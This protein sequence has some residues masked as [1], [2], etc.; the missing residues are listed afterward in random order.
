MNYPALQRVFTGALPSQ[1]SRPF[2]L[3]W[4]SSQKD[5]AGLLLIQ[6]L[7]IR[8]GLCGGIEGR[9]SCISTTIGAPLQLFLGQPVTVQLVTDQ[10]A[11]HSICA[12]VTDAHEGESDGSLATYQLVV[13]D[14]VSIMEQRINTRIF[15]TKSVVEIIQTLVQEWRRKSSTLGVTFDLDISNLDM[16]KYPVR[17]QTLQFDES[18]ANFFRR[19]CRREGIAW[20][21]R[22][23]GDQNNTDLSKQPFHALVLFDNAIKLRQAD[24][25]AV[26]YHSDAATG[27]R[28]AITLL[29]MGRQLV[30][31]SMRRASW[32]LKPSRV[33][34]VRAPTR[35]DQGPA[36]N[37]LAALLSDARIDS[38]HIAD[39]PDDYERLGMAR[40]LAH[41]ARSAIV[42][43]ASGVRDLEVGFWISVSGHPELDQLPEQQR[44]IVITSLNHAGENNL[45]KDLNERAQVLFTAS[46]WQAMAT[47]LSIDTPARPTA[48][49][50]SSASRYENTFS[51]VPR[52]TPL[53]PTYDP[54]VDLPRVYPITGTVVAPDGEQVH[55]DAY[56]RYKVQ[57]QGLDP[58]DHEHASG[59]GTSSTPADSAW[60]RMLSGW[61]G[62]SFGNQTPPRAGME[63]L[64]DFANGDPDKMY[65]AGVF[66][67]GANMPATFSRTGNLPGNRYLS[68]MRSQEINGQRYNQLRLDDTPQQISAQ[69][70]SQHATSELN[71]GFLTQPR[72]NGQGANRG[73]GAELRT[74]AAAA[75]RAAQGI[76]LTTYARSQASGNQLDRKEL[77]QLLGECTELF[78]SLGDYA[79]QHGGQAADT[80]GQTAVADAFKNWSPAAGSSESGTAPST[81]A[82]Q[83]LMAFGAQAGSVNVTPKTHVTYAGQNID[84][85]AQQHLQFMSGQR[86]NATAGQG[87]QLFA[88]GTGIQ[89]IAGEGPVLLQ[90]QADALTA[91]AQKGVKISS[92]ENEV[93]VTAPTILFVAEDGSYIRIGSGITLGTNGDIRLLSASHKWGGPSTQGAPKSAFNNQPTDQRF[94]LHYPADEAGETVA[95]ANR[96]YRITLDDGRVIEGKSDANGLTDLVKDEAMRIA[97]IDIL[98][99][100]APTGNG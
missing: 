90:A 85:V 80:G 100:P 5:L 52:G 23:G 4:R 17:E 11:L 43:G 88:R 36:G 12:I 79:G 37:D 49:D 72:E 32:D 41:G 25:G 24:A 70:S 94:R 38:P 58:A 77:I 47:P 73:E 64:L 71:L 74:D 55:T 48:F 21:I 22:A 59:A 78:K 62:D 84:Q 14:A 51:G 67:N 69:L 53:T 33:D 2:R 86:F 97:K 83:A 19:L 35:V 30:A 15:R 27:T 45:P 63:V 91:N 96:P 20:F 66:S 57:I 81:S 6:R 75:L 34:Q 76:L 39:T 10:G 28:D 42:K 44:R 3:Y 82:A 16:S 60:V 13:R 68:G 99:P 95:A 18:D 56:G 46:R 29:T 92:N 93:L 8:E 9:L 54:R 7:D 26:A 89:A 40:L 65:I 1:D 87:M 61:A 98:Q 50:G 31:G